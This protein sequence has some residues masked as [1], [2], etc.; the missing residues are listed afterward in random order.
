MFTLLKLKWDQRQPNFFKSGVF[1]ILDLKRFQRYFLLKIKMINFAI[2]TNCSLIT[3]WPYFISSRWFQIPMGKLPCTLQYPKNSF[4]V[5]VNLI[6]AIKLN[7]FSNCSHTHWIIKPI[8]FTLS[9]TKRYYMHFKLYSVWKKDWYYVLKT[10]SVH[11]RDFSW[12]RRRLNIY[13]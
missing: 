6:A 3:L 13:W 1:S 4:M 5:C 2:L 9:T 11:I 12:E 8:Y 10:A 7:A